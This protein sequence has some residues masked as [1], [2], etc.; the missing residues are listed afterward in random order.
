MVYKQLRALQ[1]DRGRPLPAP[2]FQHRFAN[3]VFISYTHEDDHEE[4]GLRWVARFETELRARL[5]KV[6]GQSIQMWRD[7]RLSGADR[8]KPEIEQQLLSSAVLVA[9][10]TPS[11]FRSEWCAAERNRFIEWSRANRGLYVANKA[12][13]VKAAKTRVPLA[14]Y[15]D[16]LRELLEFRFYVEEPNGTAREFHLSSDR[17]VRDRFFMVVDDVAQAIEQILRGLET[18]DRIAPIAATG[19]RRFREVSENT[20]G[21]Y[22]PRDRLNTLRPAANM[23]EWKLDRDPTSVSKTSSPGMDTHPNTVFS[24]IRSGSGESPTRSAP[25]SMPVFRNSVSS[26]AP[27]SVARAQKSAAGISWSGRCDSS[28][29][30]GTC[31]TAR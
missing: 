18:P 26:A 20:A 21:R 1:S 16:E 25:G 31:S 22:P 2:R 7:N 29:A 13:V 5:A 23:I 14:Q 12:R 24:P 9:V 10:V 11:Y 17:E 27:A 4:A 30:S 15:P 8:F 6:S 3:D 19:V 28:A